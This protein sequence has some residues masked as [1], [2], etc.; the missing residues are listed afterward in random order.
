M[1]QISARSAGPGLRV[2]S[3]DQSQSRKTPTDEQI[4]QSNTLFAPLS[5][6]M[7]LPKFMRFDDPSAAAVSLNLSQQVVVTHG[8]S[9]RAKEAAHCASGCCSGPKW[10]APSLHLPAVR[11]RFS[12]AGPSVGR[13]GIISPPLFVHR[14]VRRVG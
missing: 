4:E 3:I 2:D 5:Q 11:R 8:F 7:M 1:H 10:A 6:M 9:R 13:A 14:G 12:P